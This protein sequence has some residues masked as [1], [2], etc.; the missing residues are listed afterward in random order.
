MD[1]EPYKAATGYL[2]PY[3]DPGV[4]IRDENP[5][6]IERAERERLFVLFSVAQAASQIPRRI[7]GE[8]D[9]ME[10]R[11]DK[12][13]CRRIAHVAQKC[14][15]GWG[16]QIDKSPSRDI[17]KEAAQV[18]WDK[19][20]ETH[21][22]ALR[23]RITYIANWGLRQEDVELQRWAKSAVMKLVNELNWLDYA[24]R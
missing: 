3:Y 19:W 6:E 23:N 1:N 10:L 4:A 24:L 22:I 9:Y 14:L 2:S 16:G 11:V 12:R 8:A 5:V 18:I 17:K 21:Q 20:W 15:I 7:G 13:Q